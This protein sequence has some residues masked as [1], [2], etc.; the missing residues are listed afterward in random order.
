MPG[1][2]RME[3]YRVK[4]CGLKNSIWQHLEAMQDLILLK[5]HCFVKV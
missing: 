2:L 5:R 4:G 3:L 1:S